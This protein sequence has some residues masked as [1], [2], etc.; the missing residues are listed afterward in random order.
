MWHDNKTVKEDGFYDHMPV[1][2]DITVHK[3]IISQISQKVNAYPAP[4]KVP[5]PVWPG[6]GEAYSITRRS[7]VADLSALRPASAG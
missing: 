7:V 6:R 2:A 1:C 3:S 4:Q 5:R